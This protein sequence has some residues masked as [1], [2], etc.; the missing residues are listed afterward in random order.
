VEAQVETGLPAFT[1]GDIMVRVLVDVTYPHGELPFAF[2][3][4]VTEPAVTSAAL[5]V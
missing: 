3:V 5:G 2:N 4:S 1:E